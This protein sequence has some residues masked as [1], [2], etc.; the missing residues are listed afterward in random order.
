MAELVTELDEVVD[1]VR[2]FN[3]DLTDG[4]YI[5]G[6]LSEFKHW[7]YVSELD[8]FGPSEYVGYKSMTSR[9][10]SVYNDGRDTEK[11]LREW[12]RILDAGDDQHT[13]LSVKLIDLHYVNGKNIRKNAKIHVLK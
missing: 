13:S 5:V 1:N 11:A 2:Q 12:F 3:A 10:Y 8:M 7:Y 9:E 4:I 6:K